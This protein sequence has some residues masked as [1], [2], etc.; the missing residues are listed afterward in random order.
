M[1]ILIHSDCLIRFLRYKV[2]RRHVYTHVYVKYENNKRKEERERERI[3]LH[4]FKCTYYIYIYIHFTF[5]KREE[6]I[7]VSE[8]D[9]N[10]SGLSEKLVIKWK[11]TDADYYT[12][13]KVTVRDEEG[14]KLPLILVHSTRNSIIIHICIIYLTDDPSWF[15]GVVRKSLL[16][17][18]I[19]F[20]F[21]N[22]LVLQ[23]QFLR[24]LFGIA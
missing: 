15:E 8:S 10:C 11:R 2:I 3:Y 20:I 1:Y 22:T 24:P 9:N 17:T 23:M 16:D 21:T 7:Y 5:E 14:N 6:I 12:K 13:D 19:F 4:I 18:I